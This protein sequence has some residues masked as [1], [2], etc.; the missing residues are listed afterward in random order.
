[1][2]R[3]DIER[4][5]PQIESVHGSMAHLPHFAD[6]RVSLPASL[7]SGPRASHAGAS[8]RAPSVHRP[9]GASAARHAQVA[10]L[11]ALSEGTESSSDM[12]Y[13]ELSDGGSDGG[14]AGAGAHTAERA[15]QR[16]E[17]RRKRAEA[18]RQQRVRVCFSAAM[19]PLGAEANGNAC[20][21]GK[22]WVCHVRCAV[23][24]LA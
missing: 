3:A 14:G 15:A 9:P 7:R 19:P 17:R 8:V 23:A 11:A 22:Q 16:A 18:R 24:E 5:G 13:S 2:E 10:G 21:L 20:A 12:A 6:P 1:M 4:A